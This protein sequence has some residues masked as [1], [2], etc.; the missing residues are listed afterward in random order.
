M[1]RFFKE[2]FAS[3]PFFEGNDAKHIIKSLR[4]RIGEELIV[5]DTKGT[6]YRSAITEISADRVEFKI[7]ETNKTVT[8]PT[9]FVT[10]YQCLTKGDKMD[11]VVRQAV[12]SGVSK[13]VPVLSQ[14]CVSR[15]DSGALSKKTERWQRIADEAAGQSGRGILPKVCDMIHIK[16]LPCEISKNDLS[17]FFY[18]MGGQSVDKISSDVKSVAVI[19][20]AEGGFTT[21]E[22]E[23][24]KAAG[25]TVST[26]GPRIF[27]T[28]TAPIAALA[29]IMLQSGNM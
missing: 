23:M 21:Q 25:A 8:E 3:A 6:D 20:G 24:L 5:C 1:P 14:N 29:A 15:P 2:D 7:L 9:V 11:V 28:E 12:E 26:L 22:A 13:I 19:I 18:E 17:L 27:R 4:M 10:L 16:D